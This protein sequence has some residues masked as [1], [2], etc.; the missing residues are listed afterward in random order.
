MF[1]AD[2]LI[3]DV[4]GGNAALTYSVSSGRK[5]EWC[6]G[7]PMLVVSAVMKTWAPR[8]D[9]RGSTLRMPDH[10][11]A[12]HGRPDAGRATER[13]AT[14]DHDPGIEPATRSAP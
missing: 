11:T 9:R 3:I 13:I 4:D 12:A 2:H 8:H 7:M 1:T 10:E 14:Q 6:T 5:S